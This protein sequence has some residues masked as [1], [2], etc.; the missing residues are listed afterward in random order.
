MKEGYHSIAPRIPP[1][2][3]LIQCKG[4][5]IHMFLN[6]LSLPSSALWQLW[7][8]LLSV[9]VPAGLMKSGS[10]IEGIVAFK[11]HHTANVII[12][13]ILRN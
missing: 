8:F 4:Q 9:A 6:H 7:L 5:C 11:A 3:L 13:F 10:V 1:D 2:P 12:T